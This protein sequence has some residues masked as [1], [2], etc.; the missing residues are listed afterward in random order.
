LNHYFKSTHKNP[1]N[2]KRIPFRFLGV[3][4]EFESHENIFS[5]DHVDEGT[6]LLL[7]SLPPLQNDSK[8]LDL[9]CGYGVVGITIKKLYPLTSVQCSDIN[10]DALALCEL[11]ANLN[12][13]EVQC[14]HSDGFQNIQ[15]SFDWIIFNPPIRIGKAILYP[16]YLECMKHLETNGTLWMVIRKDKGAQSTMSFLKEQGYQVKKITQDKGFWIIA[17]TH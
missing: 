16:L 7:S 3:D 8:I 4:I 6:Q 10:E 12:K 1:L 5:K 15:Q 2:R 9:G 11:N 13:V 14:I 17:C